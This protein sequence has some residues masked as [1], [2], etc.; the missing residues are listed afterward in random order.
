MKS[1]YHTTSIVNLRKILRSNELW[2]KSPDDFVSLS[3]SPVFSD[4]S[5]NEATIEFSLEISS[6]FDQVKYSESWY[7]SHPEQA[8]Y[9]AG[10]GWREQFELPEFLQRP[11]ADLSD[12]EAD[13]WEPE[14]ELVE[15]A[16]RAGELNSFLDKSVEREWVSKEQGMPVSFSP[17]AVLSIHFRSASAVGE[18]SMEYPQYSYDLMT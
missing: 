6:Q 1:L 3:E 2:A 5:G 16:E 11:P 15:R 18:F 12:E 9:I 10:D 17:S 7:D 4:I 14:P 8:A 13:F